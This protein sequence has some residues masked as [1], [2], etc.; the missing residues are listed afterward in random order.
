MVAYDVSCLMEY[1]KLSLKEACEI[2]VKNKLVKIGG[3]GGLI[4]IDN[5]GNIE[6]SFNSEGMYRGQIDI[7][8][9]IDVKIYK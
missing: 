9:H 2:V 7:N 8:G 3:E 6:L 4:A 1:G 5:A